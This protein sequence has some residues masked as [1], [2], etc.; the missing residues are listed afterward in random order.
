MGRSH[1]GAASRRVAGEGPEAFPSLPFPAARKRQTSERVADAS[2][3]GAA[4]IPEFLALGLVT[5]SRLGSETG[6]DP[7]PMPRAPSPPL[8]GPHLL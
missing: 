1:L 5:V 8:P 4:G 3:T 7:H 2:I 6:P